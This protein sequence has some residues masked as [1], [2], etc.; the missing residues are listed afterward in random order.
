MGSLQASLKGIQGEED[1]LH[2]QTRCSTSLSEL[3]EGEWVGDTRKVTERGR[4]FCSL[5]FIQGGQGESLIPTS[6][7]QFVQGK[8]SYRWHI[9]TRISD[10]S[11]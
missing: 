7:V 1:T 11:P 10:E 4:C 9:A 3:I 5:K 2:S 6:K 8:F